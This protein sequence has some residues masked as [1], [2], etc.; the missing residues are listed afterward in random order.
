[1]KNKLFTFILI[2]SLVAFTVTVRLNDHLPNVTPVTAITLLAGSFLR[3]RWAALVP[4]TAMAVSDL[5]IG[6]A[7]LPITLAVYGSFTAIAFFGAWLKKRRT[8]LKITG[9][10]VASSVLFYLVTNAAVWKFSGLYEPTMEGLVLC[11]YL[12]I[13]F[14]R[15]SLLGNIAYTAGLFLAAH[16]AIVLAVKMKQSYVPAFK[17]LMRNQLT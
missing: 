9:A 10:A 4:L 2:A 8:A 3:T 6:F 16:F 7:S 14:F 11:Y 5:F 17:A 13:P 12:A 15:N 1:M